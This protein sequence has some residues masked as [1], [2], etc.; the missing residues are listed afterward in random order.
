MKTDDIIIG[1]T[2]AFGSGCTTVGK[3]LEKEGYEYIS[4]SSY[5]KKEASIDFSKLSPQETRKVLQDIGNKKRKKGLGKLI[6][7]C[8]FALGKHKGKNVVVES[9]KN[10][11]EI[12]ALKK[13]PNAVVIAIDTSFEQRQKRILTKEYGDDLAQFKKDDNREKGE[14]LKYGQNLQKCV[15]MADILMNN[16]QE[17]SSPRENSLFKKSVLKY[18]DLIKT[19]GDRYPTD[20][21]LWMNNAYSISLKS[22]CKKRQVGAVI[23]KDG[24]VISSGYNKVPQGEKDCK[25]EYGSKCYRDH[26]RGQLKFCSFCGKILNDELHCPDDD[27]D[28][29]KSKINKALDKCRSLH[30]EESAILQASKLGG[31]SLKGST[32]YVTTYP[33]KLC[34]NKIV[35]V[36]IKEVVYVESYPDKE[37]IDFFKRRSDVKLTKFEGVKATAFHKLFSPSV[38]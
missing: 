19:P 16:D 1:V 35:T 21:E 37:A 17:R 4:V 30:A 20:M 33:C 25:D 23:V 26:V 34:A 12:E 38:E 9:L 32:M 7:K 11:G 2:G 5:L 13:Y 6:N 24:Y 18:T 3:I 31:I 28:F 36:G 14:A 29:N 27:C 8:L 10:P 22:A 15:D